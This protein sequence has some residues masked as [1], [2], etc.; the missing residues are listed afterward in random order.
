MIPTR[1][2]LSQAVALLL[3]LS[4]FHVCLRTVAAQQQALGRLYTSGDRDIRV[5]NEKA[6]TGMTILD[7]AQLETP[8]CT[9]ATVRIGPLDVVHLATNSS[10]VINYSDGRVKVTLKQGCVR[11][12]AGQASEGTVVTPDGK[13]ITATQ[14]DATNRKQVEVCYPDGSKSDFDPTCKAGGVPL[15]WIVG[16]TVSGLAGVL[17]LVAIGGSASAGD[18]PSDTAPF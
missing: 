7:G 3:A 4:L 2:R 12:W 9:T 17:T 13:L 6:S 16:L 11:V 15:P 8:E 18:N 14:L 10:A 1:S 5:D